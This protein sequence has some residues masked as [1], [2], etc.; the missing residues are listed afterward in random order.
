MCREERLE[1][2]AKFRYLTYIARERK[3]EREE[4]FFSGL[5]VDV[6]GVRRDE[7]KFFSN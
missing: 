6:K 4:S 5:L 3:K 1:L 2:A 7:K